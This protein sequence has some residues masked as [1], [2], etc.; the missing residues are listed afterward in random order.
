MKSCGAC[1]ASE[2]RSRYG[3]PG[4]PSG[5]E[6]IFQPETRDVLK[7]SRVVCHK[8]QIVDQG[9]SGNH[10]VRCWNRDAL[11]KQAATYLVKLFRT[12]VIEIQYLDVVEQVGDFLEQWTWIADVICPGIE[13]TQNDGGNEQATAVLDKPMR[14]PTRSAKMSRTDVGVQQV[15]HS[16][17]I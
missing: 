12:V 14:Q 3:V 2:N 1:N 13:L 16:S 5:R 7:I 11:L 6:P 8:G 15:A 9:D 10:Q 4:T 17:S